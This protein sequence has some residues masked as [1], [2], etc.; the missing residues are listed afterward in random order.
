[1]VAPLQ[2]QQ[3]TGCRKT[4]GK[5]VKRTEIIIMDCSTPR[6]ALWQGSPA[7]RK[8]G[9][10][11]DRVRRALGGVPA[12]LALVPVGDAGAGGCAQGVAAFPCSPGAYG[13]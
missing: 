2:G 9:G 13:T 3:N 6:L 12:G 4:W 5:G 10:Y 1:M 8:N 7:C 11:P